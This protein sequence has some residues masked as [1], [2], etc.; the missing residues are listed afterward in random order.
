MLLAVNSGG[1]LKDAHLLTSLTQLKQQFQAT[2][3]KD[4]LSRQLKEAPTVGFSA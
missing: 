1:E 3:A 4:G 2:A